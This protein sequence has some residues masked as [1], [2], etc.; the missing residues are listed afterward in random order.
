METRKLFLRILQQLPASFVI[1]YLIKLVLKISLG[2]PC[3]LHCSTRF[4]AWVAVATMSWMQSLSVNN[5]QKS[6]EH[7]NG[8]LRGDFSSGRRFL[9]PGMT[10]KKT[11]LQPILYISKMFV[12]LNLENTGMEFLSLSFLWNQKENDRNLKQYK[13][14]KTHSRN[15]YTN[16]IQ[17]RKYRRGDGAIKF[18]IKLYCYHLSVRN[19]Y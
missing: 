2:F 10:H 14:K 3:T 1:S 17:I 15:S 12:G 16:R 7:R 11:A 4:L 8:M 6:K 18:S 5:M 13:N 19:I 9:H